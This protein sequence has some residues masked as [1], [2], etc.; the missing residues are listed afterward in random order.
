MSLFR[1]NEEK[2]LPGF[3]RNCIIVNPKKQNRNLKSNSLSN[4]IGVT[5][6]NKFNISEHQLSSL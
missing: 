6:E 5:L 2:T 3:G 1:E 4:K